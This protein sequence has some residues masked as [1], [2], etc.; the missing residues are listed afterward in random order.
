MLPAQAGVVDRSAGA[1]WGVPAP[2]EV[3]R[4][5]F[6]IPNG[7]GACA[8]WMHLAPGDRARPGGVV[9]CP[10]LGFEYVHSYRTLLHLS[11]RLAREG[12]STIRFDYHGTGSSA[13]DPLD[14]G[15]VDRWIDNVLQ[16]VDLIEQLT[17][18]PASLVGLRL[19]A[20]LGAV[21]ASL[22]DIEHFVAWAPVVSGRRYVRELRTLADFA[23]PANEV[24]RD[25][26][27]GAGFVVSNSAAARLNDIDLTLLNYR[28]RGKALVVERDDMRVGAAFPEALS[29]CG[30]ETQVVMAPGYMDMMEKPHFSRVPEEAL[31]TIGAW[32]HDRPD[33]AGANAPPKRQI[34]TRRH[35]GDHGTEE[36]LHVP[37]TPP[38]FGVL[39]TPDSKRCAAAPLL[40][41]TN[42]GSAHTAGPNR[43]YVEISRALAKLGF[44]TLRLDLR[45]L[46]DS[47]REQTSQENHPYPATA[48]DDVARTIEWLTRERGVE[49]VVIGGLCSGAYTAFR[50][51]TELPMRAITGVLMINPLT[52]DWSPNDSL[53]TPSNASPHASVRDRRKWRG[54][55]S[56]KYGLEY[57]ASFCMR[58]ARARVRGVAGTIG[59]VLG[60]R[61]VTPLGH[62]LQ[63]AS[64]A[65]RRLDFLFSEFDPGYQLLMQSAGATARRLERDGCLSFGFVKAADHS[66]S[67]RSWRRD[68]TAMVTQRLTRYVADSD[69]A[70]VSE[71]GTARATS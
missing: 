71:V 16:A 19:G 48:I 12:R 32:L 50:C 61:P 2:A 70:R 1:R 6:W 26:M 5:P 47:I 60:L 58:A 43:L 55:V 18:G 56:G 37:G 20:S 11:E 34:L 68:L 46:G 30:V 49:R 22:H 45:N 67:Q 53:A 14:L 3:E 66:F 39:T 15:T 59:D 65:G 52:F 23:R 38:L 17:G 7:G 9:I 8:A 64:V 40:L 28:I 51:S 31:E 62:A 57:V 41:L 10:P 35:S 44:S 24:P 42:A 4:L 27:E 54:L 25:F 63:E 36:L 69:V 21:A 13:G 33:S 29:A